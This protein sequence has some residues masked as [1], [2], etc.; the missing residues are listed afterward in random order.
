MTEPAP[1]TK[2]PLSERLKVMMAEYGKVAFGTYF[3]IFG[4]V[5]LGSF[6]AIRFGFAAT[7]TTSGFAGTLGA[8]YALTKLSQPVRIAA[9]LAATPLVS[10]LLR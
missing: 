5:F 6:L 1:K 7:E 10:R 8:A 3:A 9:T 4:L 2:P